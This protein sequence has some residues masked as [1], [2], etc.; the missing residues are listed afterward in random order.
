P[1]FEG[2]LLQKV[3]VLIIPQ[4]LSE[5]PTPNRLGTVQDRAGLRLEGQEVL[6]WE[7]G[8]HSR[9]CGLPDFLPPSL[10]LEDDTVGVAESGVRMEREQGHVP[11]EL[12]WQKTGVR[13]QE[14][15]V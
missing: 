8:G 2:D 13:V 6:D 7:A 3:G 15:H 9:R 5:S 11:A 10:L 12:A 14:A 4:V 1:A